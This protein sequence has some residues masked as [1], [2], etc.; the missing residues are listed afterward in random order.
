MHDPRTSPALRTLADLTAAP[1][2]RR[3]QW[4][5]GRLDGAGRVSIGQSAVDALGPRPLTTRWHHLALLVEPADGSPTTRTV[6]VDGRGRLT[7]PVWLR[8]RQPEVLVGLEV[9]GPVLL[10]APVEVLDRLGDVLAGDIR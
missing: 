3:W 10:V 4:S 9:E 2:Q 1:P 8:R 6:L 7:V 5:I